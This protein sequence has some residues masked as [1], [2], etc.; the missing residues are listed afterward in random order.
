M[1]NEVK[2]FN[3]RY[4]SSLKQY[5]KLLPNSKSIPKLL[6]NFQSGKTNNIQKTKEISLRKRVLFFKNFEA[7]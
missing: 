3:M 6:Q 7:M 4:S 2:E 1:L 5:E